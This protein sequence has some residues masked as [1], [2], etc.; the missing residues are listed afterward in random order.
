MRYHLTPVIMANVNNKETTLVGQD[1]EKKEKESSCTV[2]GNATGT[3]NV[4]HSMEVLQNIKRATQSSS[5]CTKGYLP[6]EY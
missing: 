2:D 6:K 3:A 1:V 4:E 5:N